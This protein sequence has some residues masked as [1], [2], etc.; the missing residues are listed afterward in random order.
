MKKDFE[1]LTEISVG[2][3]FMLPDQSQLPK[4]LCNKDLPTGQAV[5]ASLPDGKGQLV[6]METHLLTSSDTV[7]IIRFSVT[8][9]IL[10]KLKKV[11]L[12]N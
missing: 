3:I 4:F 1:S 5:L 8:L 7:K 2:D 11:T 10:S 6:E 9:D 12:F